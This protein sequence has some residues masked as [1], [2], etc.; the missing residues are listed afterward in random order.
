MRNMAIDAIRFGGTNIGQYFRGISIERTATPDIEPQTADIPRRMGT[1]VLGV[2]VAPLEITITGAINAQKAQDVNEI[3]RAIAR[4]IMPDEDGNLQPLVLPDAPDVTYYAIVKGS[5]GLNR[6][7]NHPSVT[8]TFLV[9]AGCAFGE[10]KRV[11]LGSSFNVDGDL[12]AWPIVVL[13]SL[14]SGST[15]TITRTATAQGTKTVK[16]TGGT[17]G[18]S[19][20]TVD[21]ETDKVTDGFFSLDSD[22]FDLPLGANSTT[23][24][25]ASGTL[26][27]RERWL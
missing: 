8:I 26:R 20:V 27:Y 9:P 18:A 24:S 22:P 3:R 15:A 6:G 25:G 4:A 7:Y 12:P 13:N 2:A 11:S 19:G 21:M 1:T 14:E 16:I 23:V 17:Y 10:E 5:T